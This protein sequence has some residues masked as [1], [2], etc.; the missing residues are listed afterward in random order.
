MRVELCRDG[1]YGSYNAY[2]WLEEN[3]GPHN[4][5]WRTKT[6]SIYKGNRKIGGRGY[7][8]I[9]DELDAIAYKLKFKL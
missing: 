9:D 1:I 8:E 2:K 7:I 5:G 6:E 4:Q 3:I